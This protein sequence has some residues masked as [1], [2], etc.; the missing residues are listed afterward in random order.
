MNRWKSGN[1]P[2]SFCCMV[3]ICVPVC[4]RRIED[5]REAVERAAKVAD[6]IELRLDCVDEQHLDAALR[7][8]GALRETASRPFILTFRPAEQGGNRAI[9]A[10]ERIDFWLHKSSLWHN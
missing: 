7:E 4:V 2:D 6:V 10:V 8:C 3:K 5:M 1:L 9:D